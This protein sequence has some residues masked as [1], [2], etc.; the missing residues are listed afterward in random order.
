ALVD[1]K[2]G[3][4]PRR[5]LA[6]DASELEE[7]ARRQIFFAKLHCRGAAGEGRERT[8]HRRGQIGADPP[9]RDEVEAEARN[10][11]LGGHFVRCPKWFLRWAR[12]RCRRASWECGPRGRRR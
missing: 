11:G 7:F 4:V 1:E 9:I 5:H 8:V 3:A 6:Q 12:K 10:P 2:R